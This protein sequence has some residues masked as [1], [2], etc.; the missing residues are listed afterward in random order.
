M[1]I[2]YQIS[3][4][5]IVFASDK[6]AA[7][8]E[9]Y[10]ARFGEKLGL[11]YVEI[12]EAAMGDDDY[13]AL[14]SHM[15]GFGQRKFKINTGSPALEENL[16]WEPGEY[17]AIGVQRKYS[18][19]LYECRQTHT[20][21]T[22]WA[23]DVTPALWL[24]IPDGSGEWQAGVAYAIGDLV[25]YSDMEYKC[26]QAHTSQVGWEPPVVPALWTIVT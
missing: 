14:C 24:V 5:K 13:A 18:G 26:I 12:D 1:R 16:D 7:T 15:A 6:P 8:I 21:Q 4:G 2:V 11:A 20:T 10:L 23:P 9:E 3:N 19:V 17:V 25:T 22:D